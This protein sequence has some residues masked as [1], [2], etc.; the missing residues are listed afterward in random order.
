M[1]LSVII[2]DLYPTNYFSNND[3]R[4]IVKELARDYELEDYV[5][6]IYINE[7]RGKAHGQYF[8]E[9]RS[10]YVN[11]C[12]ILNNVD[13][14][15]ENNGLIVN[16]RIRRRIANIFTLETIE[17]EL[18]HAKQTKEAELHLDNSLH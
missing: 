3:I 10:F 18:V 14:W 12:N 8:P 16:E 2:T 6:S 17:H 9:M 11:S 1:A 4:V 13:Y 5:Q 15:I 7:S